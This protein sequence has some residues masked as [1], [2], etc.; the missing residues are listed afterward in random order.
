MP[1]VLDIKEP[2]P[3]GD[4]AIWIIVYVELVTFGLL[5]VGYAFSRR[6]NLQMFNDSQLL[7][8]KNIGFINTLILITSS[9]F[10]IKAVQKIKNMTQH[11][12]YKSSIVAS[13]WLLLAILFGILF[14]LLKLSEFSHIFAQGITLSTNTFFMF[15]LLLTMFHFMHVSLGVIILFN[16]YQKT[17]VQGYTPQEHRG[18]ETGAIYWHLVDLL[19]IVLFPLVYIIR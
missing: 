9:F 13:Q 17:K 14:L 19:W 2:Y 16:L 1:K 15:Y 10:I 11:T 6:A 3:P 12:S 4:F 8:N 18:L 7:L 5:F